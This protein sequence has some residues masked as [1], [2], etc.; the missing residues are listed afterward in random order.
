MLNVGAAVTPLHEDVNC[1]PLG[2]GE[3]DRRGRA[4]GGGEIRQLAAQVGNDL[5]CGLLADLGQ[6]GEQAH[7]AA[8]DRGGE[9]RRGQA[10]GAERAAGADA[11]DAREELKELAVGGTQEADQP[12]DEV[13]ARGV[14]LEIL[15]G[16]QGELLAGA[17]REVGQGRG[18]DHDLVGNAGEFEDDGVAL[19]PDDTPGQAADHGRDLDDASGLRASARRRRAP[20]RAIAIASATSAGSGRRG[21]QSVAATA[22]CICRL[23][24]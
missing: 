23:L 20:A 11:L 1:Q 9:L 7:V 13:G 10:H 3:L 8:L 21:R 22:C 5:R 18:G 14:P 12:R 19:E 24:A 6:T 17:L 2:V 16:E 4:A 15:D